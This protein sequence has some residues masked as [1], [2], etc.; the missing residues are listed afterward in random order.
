MY[1]IYTRTSI[2]ISYIY[3]VFKIAS[4][5]SEF[6]KYLSK[7]FP[8]AHMSEHNNQYIMEQNMIVILSEKN[9]DEN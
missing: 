2:L 8:G 9:A 5:P 4:Y 6:L 1:S 3:K 7:T